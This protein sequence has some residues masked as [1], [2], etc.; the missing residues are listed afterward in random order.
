MIR[1]MSHPS[2]LRTEGVD[3]P[4]KEEEFCQEHTGLRN[5]D[6][7]IETVECNTRE[8]TIAEEGATAIT[9]AVE[10]DVTEFARCE[11]TETGTGLRIETCVLI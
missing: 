3:H 10:L 4:T 5:R 7:L 2:E 11:A 1:T 9:A 8:A 6:D